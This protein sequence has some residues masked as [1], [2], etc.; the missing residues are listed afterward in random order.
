MSV[1]AYTVNLSL[2]LIDFGSP[3]WHDDINQNFK[4]IDGAI[5]GILTSNMRFGV[6]TGTNTVTVT[7]SPALASYTAGL[8]L[9][10][11]LAASPTGAM[12]INVNGLGAK[13]ILYRNAAI[14]TGL[15]AGGDVASLLY[16]GT[17][18]NLIG[19]VGGS[20][21]M[22]SLTLEDGNSGATASSLADQL[23]IDSNTSTGLSILVPNGGIGR[24]FFGCPSNAIA[25][26][27]I[28]D[29]VNASLNMVN[30]ASYLAVG[31]I[32]TFESASS[33]YRFN[34]PSSTVLQLTSPVSGTLRFGGTGSTTN[35]LFIVASNGRVGINKSAPTTAL[36]VD[37]T[38]KATGLDAPLAMGSATGTLAIGNGGTGAST[39]ANARTNLGLGGLAVL[40]SVSIALGGTGAVDAA[41]ARTNIGALSSVN[42]Q[43]TGTLNRA[44]EG[45]QIGWSASGQSSGLV[46]IQALGSPPSMANGDILFE[47]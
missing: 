47:Y 34:F 15:L 31:S 23:V 37:G 14:Y 17:Q 4:N 16:D 40:N 30:G 22:T 1:S 10:V 36:E 26:Q 32:I 8:V 28:Y 39:A 41:G 11:K 29:F 20:S 43:F 38:I 12:T 42:P 9:T 3:I 6:G 45:A 5:A 13:N 18:F 2:G 27:L 21:S 44:S 7:V 46:F 35:G 24:I 33:D 25:G 19:A